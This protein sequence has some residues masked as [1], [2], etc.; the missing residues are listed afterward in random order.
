[1]I[2]Y[3]SE[4]GHY[5]VHYR[6]DNWIQLPA[7]AQVKIIGTGPKIY[8]SPGYTPMVVSAEIVQKH[9]LGSAI[10]WRPA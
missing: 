10:V 3:T 4:V 5:N 6:T 9:S 7:E 2:V 1:M 8:P